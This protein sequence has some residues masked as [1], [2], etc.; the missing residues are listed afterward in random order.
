MLTDQGV[1]WGTST[2]VIKSILNVAVWGRTAV[3]IRDLTER[4][5]DK[6]SPLHHVLWCRNQG[7]KPS[8]WLMVTFSKSTSVSPFSPTPSSILPVL[9][10]QNLGGFLYAVCQTYGK[11]IERAC[12]G[13][14]TN[15]RG[16]PSRLTAGREPAALNMGGPGRASL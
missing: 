9:E 4:Q 11:I 7:L 3:K 16:W 14:H 1:F 15:M 5:T 8:A 13:F 10:K 12:S 2:P 6:T